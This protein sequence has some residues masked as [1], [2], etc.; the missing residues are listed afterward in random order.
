MYIFIFARAQF[1]CLCLYLPKLTYFTQKTVRNSAARLW[2][3]PVRLG[4]SFLVPNSSQVESPGE[5]Q[6][7]SSG[8]GS[9][10]A[11]TRELRK[12]ASSPKIAQKNPDLFSHT[13]PP[14]S[15]GVPGH[16]LLRAAAGV[17]GEPPGSAA[18]RRLLRR[19]EER[20]GGKLRRRRVRHV[21]ARVLEGIPGGGVDQ[22]AV[23]VRLGDHA[24]PRWEYFSVRQ[25]RPEDRDGPGRRRE[26]H[27][28]VPVRV[29]GKRG[30]GRDVTPVYFFLLIILLYFDAASA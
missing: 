8:S 9:V 25:G 6:V 7:V 28:P 3:I 30:R 29:A 5:R 14:S 17:G 20:G 10:C 22:R 18:E 21:R 16:G 19:G 27:H 24:G 13:S 26:D 11:G 2:S 15:T 12:R 4:G 23:H 1:Q